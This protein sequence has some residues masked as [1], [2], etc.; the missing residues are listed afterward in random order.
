LAIATVIVIGIA[1]REWLFDERPQGERL[2]TV[3]D[4]GYP[5]LPDMTA[6]EIRAL[7][8][9]AL[10]GSAHDALN[11]VGASDNCVI[12]TQIVTEGHLDS[13][14]LEKCRSRTN[15][16]AKIA[17]ENGDGNAAAMVVSA[18]DPRQCEQAY[19]AEYWLDRVPRNKTDEPW[20]SQR[21]DLRAAQIS[22]RWQSA[23]QDD[24]KKAALKGDRGAAAKLEAQQP[25]CLLDS[26]DASVI[27]AACA[28]KKSLWTAVAAENGDRAAARRMFARMARSPLCEEIYRARFWARTA[29]IDLA[30][31][32]PLGGYLAAKE[33][34]C[35]W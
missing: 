17:A 3:L 1:H 29:E 34:A 16:W 35:G 27:L 26:G 24:L 2:S 15:F 23:G 6:G 8:K 20:T 31:S 10:E 9:G 25:G 11:L 28:A 32:S 12:R 13:I 4:R 5:V 7:K 22:C 19:R 14:R 18:L 33:R 21:A 30:Q